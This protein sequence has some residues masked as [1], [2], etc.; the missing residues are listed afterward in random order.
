MIV[1]IDKTAELTGR[2]IR[3]LGLSFVKKDTEDK[4]TITES[5]TSLCSLLKG[6]E[7]YKVI[8]GGSTAITLVYFV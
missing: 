2:N 6:Q 3:K 1:S 7:L 4:G 8:M 5:N